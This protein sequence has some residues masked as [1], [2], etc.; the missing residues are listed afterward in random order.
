MTMKYNPD[1]HHRRSI[2]LKAYDY[3]QAGAY[4]VTICTRNRA[5]LFGDV[6]DGQML[7]NDAGAMIGKW[8]N[9]TAAKFDNIKLD[10]SVIMPN[11][12]HAIIALV[13]AA[14]RGHPV[15]YGHS[16]TDKQPET[17]QPTKPEQPKTG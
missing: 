1:V 6:V 12:F 11:H 2:R 16:E 13:G 3:S 15:V 5:C 8:W 4:F 7:L 9:E 17:D 14:L 10:E